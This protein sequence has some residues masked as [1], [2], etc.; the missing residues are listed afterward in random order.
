MEGELKAES[1]G[2]AESACLEVQAIGAPLMVLVKNV[3]EIDEQGCAFLKRL[4][5]AGV[6]VRAVGIYPQYVLRTLRASAA[7]GSQGREPAA[8]AS[9]FP[10][11]RR[12]N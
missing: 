6:R 12:T 5:A 2:A 3:T 11:K 10:A 7:G 1:V 4:V 8:G 9:A